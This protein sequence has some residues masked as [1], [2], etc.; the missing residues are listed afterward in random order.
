[1]AVIVRR[2][3]G[4]IF[5]VVGL[6]GHRRKHAV[7]GSFCNLEV[8]GGRSRIKKKAP[9]KARRLV[10]SNQPRDQAFTAVNA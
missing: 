4:L 7:P 8:R 10:V 6:A 5:W 9:R 3:G 1:V 2:F